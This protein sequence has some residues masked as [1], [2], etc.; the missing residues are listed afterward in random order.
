MITYNFVLIHDSKENCILNFHFEED[1]VPQIT[2]WSL[3]M[4][5]L[6]KHIWS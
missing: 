6:V 5:L 1:S 4:I 3:K 2:I